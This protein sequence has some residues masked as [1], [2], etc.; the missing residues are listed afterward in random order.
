M[1][2]DRLHTV[3]FTG[4]RSYRGE[5]E[6]GLIASLRRLAEWGYTTFLSGMAE[7][8]DLAAAEAVLKLRREG[9]AVRLVAVVPFRGQ[10]RGFTMENRAR[11]RAVLAEADEV[12][13]LSERFFRGCYQVRNDYL[14]DH[15][16]YLLAWYDGSR[17]GTQQTF[18]GALH[19][20]L[21]VENLSTIQPDPKLF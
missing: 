17:G 9:L 4:H 3:A 12:I 7:G 6:E 18:L 2:L 5:A 21:E 15:A 20:G 11:Y 19:R 10:S 1:L 14:V 13:T 8:F 16:A